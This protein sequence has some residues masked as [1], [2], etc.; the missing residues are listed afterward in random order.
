MDIKFI[1]FSTPGYP[2]LKNSTTTPNKTHQFKTNNNN[3]F[4]STNNN[5]INQF[6]YKKDINIINS[7]NAFCNN[8]LNCF[9]NIGIVVLITVML[10]EIIILMIIMKLI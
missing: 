6:D 3:E 4:K 9:N 10:Q 1:N 7:N 8:T 2:G 5:I